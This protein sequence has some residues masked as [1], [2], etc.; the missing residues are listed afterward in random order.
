[1]TRKT[2][3]PFPLNEVQELYA[4]NTEKIWNNATLLIKVG[5][6]M[7]MCLQSG[8]AEPEAYKLYERALVIE[9]LNFEAAESLAQCY[10]VRGAE[11]AKIKNAISTAARIGD[12]L[13]LAML[14]VKF[15]AECG[16]HREAIELLGKA[17]KRY[18][19]KY[20]ELNELE[21]EVEDGDWS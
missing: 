15:H 14:D 7:S 10:F 11:R 5:D 21:R 8:P 19:D 2:G 1:M 13:S 20:Q 9:P 17:K 3:A 12:S 18:A 6:L 16:K 4:S